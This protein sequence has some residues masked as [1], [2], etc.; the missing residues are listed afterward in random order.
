[1]IRPGRGFGFVLLPE[2]SASGRGCPS[3]LA[4]IRE[5]NRGVSSGPED[6]PE[7]STSRAQDSSLEI[8]FLT[9]GEGDLPGVVGP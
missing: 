8:E 3:E 6:V 5:T 1:M 7:R 2:E 9:I 4:A